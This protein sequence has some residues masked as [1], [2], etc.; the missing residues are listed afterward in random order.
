MHYGRS[1][2]IA[3]FTILFV[4]FCL[5]IRE[6]E[7]LNQLQRPM[8]FNK[9]LEM[10]VRG[11]KD[12]KA[13]TSQNQEKEKSDE[14][15]SDMRKFLKYNSDSIPT[16]SA[17]GTKNSTTICNGDDQPKCLPKFQNFETRIRYARKYKTVACLMQKSMSTILQAIICFLHNE[18]SFRNAG[19]VLSRESYAFR[20]CANKNE[21][22]TNKANTLHNSKLKIDD[23]WLHLAVVREPIDRFLS[24]FVDKCLRKPKGKNFCNGCQSNITCFLT[25]EY[26]RIQRQLKSRKFERT[27]DDRH[28]FPQNWRCD[29][30]WHLDKYRLIH[31]TSQLNAT[32]D[33]LEQLLPLL[34]KQEVPDESLQFIR[35]QLKLGRTVH[36]TTSSEARQFFEKRLRSSPFLMEYVIRLFYQDFK[37]FNYPIPQFVYD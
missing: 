20:F 7:P 17:F 18:T 37:L 32:D 31:Y 5:V 19:R 21:K 30:R 33:F 22:N 35:D 6:I 11:R 29:F 24:G 36:S 3:V 4:V 8:E 13:V 1:I 14:R 26:D 9:P 27:F 15:L 12:K 2:V 23:T 16:I 28:F 10:K 34:K 25:R